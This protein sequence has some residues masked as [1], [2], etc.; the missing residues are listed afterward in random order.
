VGIRL[1]DLAWPEAERVL[2]AEA[3]VVLPVGAAAKEHGPHLRL[4][5]DLVLA[6]HLARRVLAGTGRE[7]IVAPTLS[8]H[9]YPAFVEYPGS[10]SLR[11]ETA[12]DLTLDVVR[13]L[14]R[15]GPRRFYALNTGISTVKALAPAAEALAREGILLR[16]T[17]LARALAPA[18]QRLARQ[19]RG[20]HADEVETSMMLF[21]DP[22]R[23]DMARAVRDD[24]GEGRGVF[25]RQADVGPGR[26]RSA[27]GVW[28]DP[29]L[30]SAVKGRG[31]V[32]ALVA[33]ILADLDALHRSPT[34]PEAG[35]S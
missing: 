18:E 6:E 23:V 27:S 3:V 7:V 11:M 9:H 13:G 30:A 14:A 19:R 15:H 22:G 2:T 20:S 21:L 32:E 1:Q 12:R 25:T 5:N 29:T 4:D 16:W 24:E 33:A 10:T 28:G 35:P 34:P 8:Y 31:F 17:D 26:H